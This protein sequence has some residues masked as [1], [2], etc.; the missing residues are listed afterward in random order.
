MAIKAYTHLHTLLTLTDT[1]TAYTHLHTLTL[2]THMHTHTHTHT[3]AHVC[4]H[5]EIT[6][7]LSYM[8][9]G[10]RSVIGCVCQRNLNVNSLFRHGLDFYR[11]MM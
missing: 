6:S 2:L 1:N 9:S 4:T 11:S 10:R 5:T 8:Q 3:H 7:L